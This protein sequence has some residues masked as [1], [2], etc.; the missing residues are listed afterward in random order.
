MRCVR[1]KQEPFGKALKQRSE[2]ESQVAVQ[3]GR[4]C[5]TSNQ[6]PESTVKFGGNASGRRQPANNYV[7]C[8]LCLSV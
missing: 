3:E 2:G 8:L 6:V 5:L 4:G 7:T 1:S